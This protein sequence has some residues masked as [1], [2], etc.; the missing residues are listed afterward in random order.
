MGIHALN[1]GLIATL[2]HWQ[3]RTGKFQF[4]DLTTVPW[5]ITLAALAVT[6]FGLW[7]MRPP[8]HSPSN[9]DLVDGFANIPDRG[10]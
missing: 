1:N 4:T 5:S 8:G 9:R 3:A 7:L 6:L 2:I 10:S